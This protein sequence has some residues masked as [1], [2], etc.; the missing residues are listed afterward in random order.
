MVVCETEK[1]QGN[2]KMRKSKFKRGRRKWNGK[3]Y[4]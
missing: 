1:R 3:G 2:I 4:R